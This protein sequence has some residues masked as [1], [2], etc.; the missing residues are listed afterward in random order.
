MFNFKG[1]DALILFL[2]NL[3]EISKRLEITSLSSQD[4]D[5]VF[6]KCTQS[7]KERLRR[8]GSSKFRRRREG[9]FF[10]ERESTLDTV[11]PI[12]SLKTL[13]INHVSD[14][15]ITPRHQRKERTKSFD[16]TETWSHPP[17]AVDR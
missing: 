8:A 6:E 13:E 5:D 7:P 10:S 2:A 14:S 4:K 3:D 9:V 1:F 17:S 11:S 12:G 16:K 15:E